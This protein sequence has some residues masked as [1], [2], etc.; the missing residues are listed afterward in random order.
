MCADRRARP[1]PLQQPV[2]KALTHCEDEET[3]SQ[4]SNLPEVVE[5]LRGSFP[6]HQA[7]SNAEIQP[8]GHSSRTGVRET[9]RNCIL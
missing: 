2:G 3:E 6:G 8:S 9:S 1:Q 7:V 4:R 5:L